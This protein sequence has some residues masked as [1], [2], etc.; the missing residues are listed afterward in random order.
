MQPATCPACGCDVSNAPSAT[1]PECGVNVEAARRQADVCGAASAH[2]G[3]LLLFGAGGLWVLLGAWV[4][5]AG[6]KFEFAFYI[7]LLTGISLLSVATAAVVERR[8]LSRSL[9]ARRCIR[10]LA[11]AALAIPLTCLFAVL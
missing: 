4:L 2:N 3:A 10:A 1:C 8:S 11:I 5:G 6:D 7:P 9:T